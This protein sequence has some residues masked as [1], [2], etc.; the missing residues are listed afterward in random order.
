MTDYSAFLSQLIHRAEAARG[1]AYTPYSHFSVGAALLCR[2]DV[3][4]I[5][6]NSTA[7]TASAPPAHS[8]TNSQ[9]PAGNLNSDTSVPEGDADLTI[10]TGCNIENKAY[11]SSM[12]AERTAVFKAV[13][14]GIRDFLAIAIVGGPEGGAP[15]DY[16]APCGACRQVLSEF[17]PPDFKII[18]AKS[19]SDYKIYTLAELLPEAFSFKRSDE[20]S[21]SISRD[22]FS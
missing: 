2:R 13:S 21:R 6:A 8:R 22:S 11:G 18:L 15:L 3:R 7:A 9:A 16:C 10:L 19:E 14:E 5:P 20:N 1:A 4:P 12:C 17:A